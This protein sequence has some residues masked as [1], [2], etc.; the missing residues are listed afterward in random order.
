MSDDVVSI[1]SAYQDNVKKLFA[2]LLEGVIA[3]DGDQAAIKG[4]EAR[5]QNGLKLARQARDLA[6]KLVADPVNP[7]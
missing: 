1:G 6:L 5:F 3:A 7:P 4:S 2:G